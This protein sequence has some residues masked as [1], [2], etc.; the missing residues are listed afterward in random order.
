MVEDE[1]ARGQWS[2]EWLRWRRMGAPRMFDGG[3]MAAAKELCLLAMSAA[4]RDDERE[5]RSERCADGV[6]ERARRA[7]GR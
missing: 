4:H 6:N 7:L 2:R 3:R 1:G 5:Q